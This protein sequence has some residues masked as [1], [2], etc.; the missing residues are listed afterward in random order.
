MAGMYRAGPAPTNQRP[1][2]RPISFILDDAG[3]IRPPVTLPIRPEDLNRIESSRATV[4]QTLGRGEP[5]PIGWVDNFGEALP[6]VTISGH[7]GWRYAEGIGRDGWSSFE[8]L[9]QLVQHDYHEAKQAAIDAGRDP[10][11][12]Q[13]LFVDALDDFAWSVVPTQFVLRRSKSRPLLYQYQIALQAISTVVER[14]NVETPNYGNSALALS[15]LLSATGS[16]RSNI[17][18]LIFP[19]TVL[20]P[21]TW[22]VIR[23]LVDLTTGIFEAV[24]SVV[25]GVRNVATAVANQALVLARDMAQVGINVFRTISAVINLPGDIKAIAARIAAA[26]NEVACIFANALRPRKPYEQYDGLYG[27]SN[28]SSTTGGRPPSPYANLNVFELMLPERTPVT[29]TSSAL[30]SVSTLSSADPVLAPMPIPEV[31]RNAQSIVEG[32]RL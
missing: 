25:S 4:H 26:Y 13:L 15:S 2:V 31:A 7:T 28:C 27:A 29:V 9:N 16:I 32:V 14:P 12:V 11:E 20:Q 3:Q 19:P 5:G 6:S 10:A 21:S 18:S 23:D 30:F 17:Q 24:N 1:N 8:A 22:S